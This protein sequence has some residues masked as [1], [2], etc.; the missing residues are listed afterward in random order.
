MGTMRLPL[1]APAASLLSAWHGASRGVSEWDV[2]L[3]NKVK[4]YLI[5]RRKGKIQ[6]GKT[7]VQR[8]LQDKKPVKVWSNGDG[9]TIYTLTPHLLGPLENYCLYFCFIVSH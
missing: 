5:V 2:S 4:T 1:Q 8:E 9:R 7:R 6:H 3:I